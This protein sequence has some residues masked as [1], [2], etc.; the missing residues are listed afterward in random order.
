MGQASAGSQ[1]K[2]GAGWWP[3]LRLCHG[4]PSHGDPIEANRSLHPDY[5]AAHAAIPLLRIGHALHIGHAG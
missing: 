2:S 3:R 1:A 4:R 5:A